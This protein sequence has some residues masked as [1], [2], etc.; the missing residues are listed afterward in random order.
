M[1]LK[2][3]LI[4]VVLATA[5]LLL[6]QLGLLMFYFRNS[7]SYDSMLVWLWVIVAPPLILAYYY[8]WR[9]E[10]MIYLLLCLM[11]TLWAWGEQDATR[12]TRLLLVLVSVI[13]LLGIV[14]DIWWYV[15][16]QIF[17]PLE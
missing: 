13:T 17:E 2:I 10:G 3:R 12:M 11:A 9:P 14:Y 7:W 5:P 6:S 1:R 4:L 15:T 8:L 16:G